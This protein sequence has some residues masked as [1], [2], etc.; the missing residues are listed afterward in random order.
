MLTTIISGGQTGANRLKTG[1]WMGGCQKDLKPWIDHAQNM[2]KYTTS[3]STK[4]L[5]IQQ[6]LL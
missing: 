5:D 2:L 1:G 4:I 6:E 3:K